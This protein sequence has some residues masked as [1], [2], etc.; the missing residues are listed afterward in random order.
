MGRPVPAREVVVKK[1]ALVLLLAVTAL[2]AFAVIP[3]AAAPTGIG[4]GAHGGYSQSKD[5][6]SGSPL[7]GAHVVVNLTSWLGAVASAE[8]K[9]KEDHVESGID[10]DVSSYPVMLM[11]RVYLP[12]ESFSPYVA[13]GAQYKIIKYGGDLFE[14][15]EVDDSENSFG[16]VLGAGA[17]FSSGDAL[18]IFGEVL[19]ELN[20]P[21]RDVENAIDNAE[22][23][24]YD[25][26]SFRAGITLYFN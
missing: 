18:E 26:M 17:S 5:A 24:N 11:G 9:F 4:I 2:V 15:Y 10:F 21:E 19:Y 3:A 7:A 23:F 20:D 12:M 22:D 1:S 13:A 8:F 14:D 16:W 6:E 25:Q